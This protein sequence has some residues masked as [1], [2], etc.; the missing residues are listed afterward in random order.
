[1]SLPEEKD[2]NF[3]HGWAKPNM[4]RLEFQDRNQ[5]PNVGFEDFFD[6]QDEIIRQASEPKVNHIKDGT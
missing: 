2:V 4:E 1:M 6:A 5:G 3:D